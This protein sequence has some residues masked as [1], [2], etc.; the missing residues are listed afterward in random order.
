M[1]GRPW[2]L[3]ETNWK[4]VRDTTYELAVLP[5][6]AT[7][8]HNYHLPFGTD[9]IQVAHVAA[10]AARRA[11]EAGTR[12]IVLPAIP[13]GV[14]TGQ[15]DIPLCVNLNPST[16]L[17]ML[18]DMTA[19]LAGQGIRKLLIL[20]GHGGNNFRAIIRELQPQIGLF[21]C[22]A[23]WFA[24][25]DRRLY[26]DEPGDHADEFETSVVQHV[27]PEL[28]LPLDQAG[29]GREREFRVA[30]LRDG[31]VWAP[32]QWTQVT[33]DTGTG[34]PRAATPAKGAAFVD[35]VCERLAQFF[36]EFAAA[37]LDAMYE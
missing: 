28:V 18:R 31:W 35:A 17:A 24:C 14:Q 23:D 9:T 5:W 3:E 16:Q 1:S 20:N 37:D 34:D 27:A 2:L 12:V 30:G 21:L 29:S 19:C 32:R 8:A 7:E 33:D 11:W 22:V 6:G 25:I 10:E 13:Y 4:S 36:K 26:F 15:L